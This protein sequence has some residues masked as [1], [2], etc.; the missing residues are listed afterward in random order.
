MSL[1]ADVMVLSAAV[2]LGRRSVR[3][4][5]LLLLTVTTIVLT[6]SCSTN[7]SAPGR[8]D[9]PVQAAQAA[10]GVVSQNL[11]VVRRSVASLYASHISAASL[12]RPTVA[13]KVTPGSWSQSGNHAMLEATVT[14]RGYPSRQVRIFLVREQGR[15]RVLDTERIQR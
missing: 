4:L 6:A 13:L 12:A 9:V 15:W 10:R 2:R 8:T 7:G 5:A 11:D 3:V 1:T 14:R